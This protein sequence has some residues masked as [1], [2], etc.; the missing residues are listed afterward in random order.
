MSANN[1]FKQLEE[2]HESLHP[3]TPPDI[4]ENVMGNMRVIHY[5]GNVLELYLPKVVKLFISMLG[6]HESSSNQDG[7]SG[8]DSGN[9]PEGGAI[10]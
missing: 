7:E 1:S 8:K 5:M 9:S 6:G 4:E 10:H 3:H 2:E